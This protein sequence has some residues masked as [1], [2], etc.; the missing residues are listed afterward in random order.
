MAAP[1]N[2]PMHVHNTF[3]IS[4]IVLFWKC[5]TASQPYQIVTPVRAYVM[6]GV[7]Y[8]FFQ[9]LN[10]HTISPDKKFQSFTQRSLPIKQSHTIQSHNRGI[11]NLTNKSIF[12]QT[13][14]FTIKLRAVNN[15]QLAIFQN[16]KQ[17]EFEETCN[18]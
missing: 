2:H 9:T 7:F 10:I 4:L 3:S 11:A 6:R 1:N 5:I 18:P 12:N 13:N 8:A 15:N 16:D 17:K 14:K